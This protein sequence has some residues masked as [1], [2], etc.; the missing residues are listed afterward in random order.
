[1]MATLFERMIGL[2][3]VRISVHSVIS[4]F[5][6]LHR[7]K[8]SVQDI[9]TAFDLTTEQQADMQAIWN[10]IRTSSKPLERIDEFFDLIILG[11]ITKRTDNSNYTNETIFKA[12]IA[13]FS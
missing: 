11:E 7:E 12:R 8:I 1:M 9:I 13:S 4:S 3:G 10:K 5:K 2:D 6:E